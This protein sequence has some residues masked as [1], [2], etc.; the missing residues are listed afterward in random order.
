MS[1][2]RSPYSRSPYGRGLPTL[3]TIHTPTSIPEEDSKH[4]L[5]SVDFPLRFGSDCDVSLTTDDAAVNDTMKLVT[6]V[7]KHGVPL[8]PLGFG[9]DQ[10]VFELNDIVLQTV[11]EIDLSE[12]LNSGVDGIMVAPNFDFE[13]DESS[14]KVGIPYMNTK[15]RKDKYS[16]ISVPKV[17]T[18]Q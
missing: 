10:F 8:L 1:Y 16:V 4:W 12:N 6:F 5:M 14:L 18:D 2:A 15:V 3:G 17:R 9:V 13:A 11:I 7:R